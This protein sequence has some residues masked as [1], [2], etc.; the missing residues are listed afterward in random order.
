MNLFNYKEVELKTVNEGASKLKIRWLINREIGAKNFAMRL[1]EMEPGGYS[2][3]HSH[4]WE[5]EVFVLEGNGI[6]VNNTSKKSFKSGDVIYVPP[7]EM[8]QFRNE[9]KKILKFLCLIPL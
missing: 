9:G 7:N 8:H 4:N 3:L 2:P 1:F 5:H 6:L